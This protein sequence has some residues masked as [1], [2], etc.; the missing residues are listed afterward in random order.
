MQNYSFHN[1]ASALCYLILIGFLLSSSPARAN[2]L[3]RPQLSE[4]QQNQISGTIT[5]GKNPLPGVTI[6]I[7]NRVNFAVL[8][9]FDGKFILEAKA[10]DTLVVSYIGYKTAIIPINYRKNIHIQLQEDITSLQE[11][12]INAGYY[13]VKEKERTGSIARITAKDIETQPVTNV[14]AAMQG[15]MAGVSISQTTGAPGGGFNV[16]IRGINSLRAEGNSPLYIVDGVPYN[17][18][19]LGDS[20][21]SGAILA[22]TFSPL[23]SINPSDIASIEVLKDADATAIYGSRGAN[24]VILITTKRGIGGQTKL[25]IHSYSSIGKVTAG[26]KMMNTGEYLKMRKEAFANDGITSYP[27]NAY[28][29]NGTWD[30]TRYTDWRKELIG[31]TAFFNNLQATL[32]GGS[33]STQY[34]ISGTY[35]KETTVFPGDDHYNK[36][37][38]HSNLT[39]RSDDEKFNVNLSVSYSNNKNTIKA[40]DLTSQVYKLAP[41]APSLYKDD[42]SLNWENGTFQNPLANSLSQ[43]ENN[44]ASLIANSVIAYKLLPSLEFK[45]SLGYNDSQLKET[46]TTPSTIYNPIYG[47]TSASATL[48][49]NNG[50][51][52]S[53]IIEPQINWTNQWSENTLS[54]LLGSTFQSEKS[55]RYSILGTG[56]ASNSLINSLGAATTL[57]VTNNQISEYR[58]QAFFGRINY[59]LKDKYIINLTG[60]RDGSSRFGLGNRFAGFGAVGAAWLFSNED[61]VVRHTPWLNFGKLRGSYG[62]TGSDQIGDYQFLDTYSISNN[63]YN[64]VTGLQPTRL[65]NPHFGWETNKKLELALELGLLKD[66]IFLT[67][68]WYRNRSSNQLVGI[69]LPATTGFSLMQANLDATIQNTGI[70][71]DLR[72][73]NFKN[74][75][76]SWLTTFNLSIPKNKLLE[77]KGLEKSTYA[78]TYVIGE[79]VN[80]L[81]GFHYLGIDP[82]SG[83]YTFKD[84]DNDGQI[85]APSDRQFIN[86][87]SQKWFGGIGNLI[88]YKS[89]EMDFLFQFVK[90]EGRNY[91]YAMGFAGVMSNMPLYA[92][93]HWP[94]NGNNS[95]IQLYGTGANSAAVDAY[96]RYI[97]S[98]AAFSDASFARLKSISIAYKIPSKQIKSFSGKIYLQGQNLLTITNYKGADPENQST[99]FLPPLRQYTMGVQL[100]F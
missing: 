83:I 84:Y 21:T 64:G 15:R 33:T 82:S 70:E 13:S 29:I 37:M 3:L 40:S 45:T 92:L 93:N 35:H 7:K 1:T 14:L 94:A 26:M 59:S 32:S 12:R 75:N 8:S 24:G 55:D 69:P 44:T 66:R 97:S 99:S 53:W 31:N 81:K 62:T 19:S 47:V 80:I 30:K 87:V 74:K 41:N 6:A 79:S 95:E 61:F 17:S 5:D 20:Q 38:V 11:V 27:A 68:A 65:F 18:Q 4:R 58:Y 34:L 72:T 16:Q 100:D 63:S 50:T 98:N 52:S 43:Y 42:G 36:A 71:G 76:S 78:N 73:V 57:R 88:N 86:D 54:I 90:Q 89:W 56:F 60:R 10:N 67:A 9:D 28:D 96:Y 25:S 85:S 39:H 2:K 48:L 23:N 77:F 49:L 46:R 22:G 51:R 91:K